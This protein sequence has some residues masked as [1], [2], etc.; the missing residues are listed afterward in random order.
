MN[1]TLGHRNPTK[2]GH[3]LSTAVHVS[4]QGS[5]IAYALSSGGRIGLRPADGVPVAWGTGTSA[6]MTCCGAPEFGFGFGLRA[7][8]PV[9]SGGAGGLR[10]ALEFDGLGSPQRV[11]VMVHSHFR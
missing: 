8:R 6:D 7:L 10:K 11:K 3:A 9:A 5:S 2:L 1:C 4:K